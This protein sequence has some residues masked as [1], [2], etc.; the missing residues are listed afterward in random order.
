MWRVLAEDRR[1]IKAL[2]V[3]KEAIVSELR[4]KRGEKKAIDLELIRLRKEI[5]GIKGSHRDL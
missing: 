2:K 5:K 4:A 3:K 1:L